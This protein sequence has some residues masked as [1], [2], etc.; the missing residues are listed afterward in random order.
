[1]RSGDCFGLLAI[2]QG[3]Q[4]PNLC[5]HVYPLPSDPNPDP[6]FARVPE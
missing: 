6:G 1:M 4:K 5:S 2:C 3:K